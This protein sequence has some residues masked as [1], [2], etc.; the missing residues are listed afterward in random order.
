MPRGILPELKLQTVKDYISGYESYLSHANKLGVSE[1]VFR[2][3]VD[4]YK[5]SGKFAFLRTGHNQSLSK[6]KRIL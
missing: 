3:W 2:R 5:T 1:T 6:R 4:K